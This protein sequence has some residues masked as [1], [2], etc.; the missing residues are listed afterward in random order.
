MEQK[1]SA[2][3]V[4]LMMVLA[5]I[6]GTS[7]I[8]MK[9]GLVAFAPGQVAAIRVTVAG[10]VLLPF[11]LMTWRQITPRHASKL[12]LSGMLGV[13][14]PAF[15]FTSAQQHIDSSVAGILNTLSPLW[16]MVL[17][18]VIYRQVFTRAS[19]IGILIGLAGTVVLMLSRSQGHPLSINLYALL[20]VLACAFYGLNLNFIKF[21]IADLRSMTITSIS[22]VLIAPLAA[23]YLFGF[24]DFTSR[25]QTDPAALKSF[26]YVALLALMS[27]AVAVSIFNKLV[28]ITTP[29]FASTVTYIM[30]VVSVMWGVL[31]G[32]VLTTSHFIGLAAIL[33]GVYLANRKWR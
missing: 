3:S 16:T 8:L 2:L 32:E 9:K 30:P 31:D 13:F 17:G 28:K 26:G 18:A 10:L 20:I 27:T 15:L 23:F 4:I 19:V 21:N 12:F 24:T 11:A 14:I 25:M 5:L 6:W 29:L 1:N 33:G 22:V 7:F